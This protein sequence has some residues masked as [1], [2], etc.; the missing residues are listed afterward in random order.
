MS[1]YERYYNP[2]GEKTLRAYSTRPV[3]LKRFDRRNWMMAEEVLWEVC[4][5][6]R[7]AP[8]SRIMPPQAE[9]KRRRMDRRLYEAGMVGAV[10]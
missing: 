2:A 6:F 1:Y 4:E 10:K 5:Y 8:H 3:N 7:I 9:R